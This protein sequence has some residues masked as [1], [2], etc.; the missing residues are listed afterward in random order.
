M[1]MFQNEHL[2]QNDL[3]PDVIYILNNEGGGAS[4]IKVEEMIFL[5]HK[6][7]FVKPW[8]NQF[9]S[10][11][12]PRWKHNV[13]WAKQMAVQAGWIKWPAE[14]GRGY[15]ELTV[16]GHNFERERGH[17][18]KIEQIIKISI[19]NSN[20]DIEPKQFKDLLDDHIERVGSVKFCVEIY[21]SNK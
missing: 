2:T 19:D 4:K 10:R 7:E 16:K 3:V 18:G 17:K 20:L 21:V 5:M 11:G 13:A 9:V 12:I 1:S 8:Y 14:S 6:D 15:W